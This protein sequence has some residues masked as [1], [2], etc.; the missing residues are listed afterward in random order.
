MK[1]SSM[2]RVAGFWLLLASM[3]AQA[4]CLAGVSS[5]ST[6]NSEPDNVY[7]AGAKGNEFG[8]ELQ[9]SDRAGFTLQGHTVGSLLH[10]TSNKTAGVSSS[11]SHGKGSSGGTGA[12]SR[13]GSANA[14]SADEE[15]TCLKD[16]FG[17]KSCL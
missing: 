14:A 16:A 7:S 9:S 12:L 6:C 2:M 8:Q 3:G 5:Q 11:S 15:Q 10:D 1:T 4:Y 17:H 13:S